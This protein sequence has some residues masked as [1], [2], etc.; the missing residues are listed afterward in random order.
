MTNKHAEGFE[1]MERRAG[2]LPRTSGP[3]TPCPLKGNLCSAVRWHPAG[4]Q[5]QEVPLETCP[6]GDTHKY[7]G[8]CSYCSNEEQKVW[9]WIPTQRGDFDAEL[10]VIELAN[11]ILLWLARALD[12]PRP[13]WVE[14][15]RMRHFEKEPGSRSQ[16]RR[17]KMI[18]VLFAKHQ[19]KG[20]VKLRAVSGQLANRFRSEADDQDQQ[21]VARYWS[22]AVEYSSEE[23]RSISSATRGRKNFEPVERSTQEGTSFGECAATYLLSHALA[24]KL[25]IL[26]MAELYFYPTAKGK[27]HDRDERATAKGL[28]KSCLNCKQYLGHMLCERRNQDEGK[29][30][31]R[32]S[33]YDWVPPLPTAGGYPQGFPP[34]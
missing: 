1:D 27:I 4:G 7:G 13:P 11:Q 29:N 25:E 2:R 3:T 22:P 31:E 14:C 30:Q 20:A 32:T 5:I 24:Q 16:R 15:W 34:P 19:T 18:G 21:D 10:A 26:C 33:P 28:R 12:Q 17:G 9:H 6:H 23:V 8:R